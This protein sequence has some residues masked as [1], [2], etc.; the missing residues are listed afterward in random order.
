MN[1]SERI[2]NLKSDFSCKDYDS[3]A[4]LSDVEA[5][6]IACIKAGRNCEGTNLLTTYGRLLEAKGKR[7]DE[8]LECMIYHLDVAVSVM[9]IAA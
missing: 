7:K 2:K 1:I 3:G 4:T 5:V 6:A 8:W 9:V